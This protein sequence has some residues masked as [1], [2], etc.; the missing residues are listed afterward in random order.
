[1]KLLALLLT[2]A[3]AALLAGTATA[4]D[5]TPAYSGCG[6]FKKDAP[7]DAG[8]GDPIS[9]QSGAPDEAEIEEAWVS[10]D[11]QVFALRVKKLSDSVP[12]P[13]TSITYDAKFDAGGVKFVRAYEDFTGAVVYEYGHL[14]TIDAGAT[15]NNRYMRDGETTGVFAAG[16]HGIVG[17]TIP[18]EVGKAGTGLKA[19]TGEVQVGRS[20]VLP[21]AISQSP[22][23]G[24]SYLNDDVGLGTVT[25]GPCAGG[26]GTTT[27]GPTP[28]TTTTTTTTTTQ[29]STGAFPVKLASKSIKKAKKGKTV[30]VK[31]KSSE[32]LTDVGVRIAKGSAVYGTGKLAKLGRTGTV[33]VKL[34]KALK[35]GTYSFDVAGTDAN[36]A[37]RVG[38]LKLKV[39]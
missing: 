19:V 23:R 9:S 10:A 27:T 37:R 6:V 2:T 39:K 34:A 32:A 15:Q 29:Q 31:L 28:T 38:S 17:I 13:A 11:S 26:G 20:T 25:L 3:V 4:A 30:K 18:A 36:G 12:P 8:T 21:G 35:K 16:D 33:K 24:L 7:G 5:P 22:T 1:M 14:E